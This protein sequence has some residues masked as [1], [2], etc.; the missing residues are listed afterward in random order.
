MFF[1]DKMFWS[2]KTFSVLVQFRQNGGKPFE[3]GSMPYYYCYLGTGV[4][5]CDRISDAIHDG[6]WALEK[7]QLA[8][9]SF[10]FNGDGNPKRSHTYRARDYPTV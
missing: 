3:A 6:W 5:S 9:P 8:Q 10:F 2:D 7:D 1:T 4:V